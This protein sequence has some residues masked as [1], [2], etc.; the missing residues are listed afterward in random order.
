MVT[1]NSEDEIECRRED[2][3]SAR[4]GRRC[5]NSSR[6]LNW[7]LKGDREWPILIESKQSILQLCAQ[8]R[9]NDLLTPMRV[10]QFLNFHHTLEGERVALAYFHLDEDAQLWY[11]TLK[12][13]KGKLQWQDFSDG[14]H[15]QFGPTQFQDFFG[16]LTKLLQADV[17]AGHPT[18]L[19]SAIGLARL[20]KARNTSQRHFTTGGEHAAR[21]I[22]LR[23]HF[24]ASP[25]RVPPQSSS[26]KCLSSSHSHSRRRTAISRRHTI[27]SRTAQLHL[28]HLATARRRLATARRHLATAPHRRNIFATTHLRLLVAVSLPLLLFVSSSL[29]R[30]FVFHLCILVVMKFYFQ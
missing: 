6:T 21:H 1:K 4:R 26:L 3:G 29:R 18:S 24:P 14:L 19:T 23:K 13:E 17:L 27:T 20:Y 5:V 8:G 30:L 16:D 9:G 7:L 2:E 25:P 28:P 15:A 11:Q 10:E 22:S 12:Q